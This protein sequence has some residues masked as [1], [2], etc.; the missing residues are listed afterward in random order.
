MPWSN[1]LSCGGPRAPLTS[2][3][4]VRESFLSTQRG[5]SSGMLGREGDDERAPIQDS[6]ISHVLE[7]PGEESSAAP[8]PKKVSFGKQEV[9]EYVVGSPLLS[10]EFADYVPDDML[11]LEGAPPFGEEGAL[12][13]VDEG[14]DPEPFDPIDL[15]DRQ[16]PEYPDSWMLVL[17]P[18]LRHLDTGLSTLRRVSRVRWLPLTKKRVL[19]LLS[20]SLEGRPQLVFPRPRTSRSRMMLGWSWLT[21]LCVSMRLKTLHAFAMTPTSTYSGRCSNQLSV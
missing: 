5:A 2:A 19:L 8:E 14:E 9:R 3:L 10:D 16:P 13:G 21:S 15:G 17:L 6:E 20:A 1:H 18:P 12:D 11:L 7:K 4:I